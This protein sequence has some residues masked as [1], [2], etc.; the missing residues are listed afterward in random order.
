MTGM[1]RLVLLLV[2][3]LMVGCGSG[4]PETA[5]TPS[6]PPEPP[7]AETGPPPEPIPTEPAPPKG[8]PPAVEETRERIAA[9]ALAEDYEALDALI[10]DTGFTF[11][12]GAGDRATDYW[13][14]LEAS[15]EEPLGTMVGL[16]TLPHTR[17]GDIYVWP[18]AYD[19]DPA[20]LTDEE[21]EALVGAGAAT[22]AQLD[23]MAEFGHYLGWRLGIRRDGTWMF[24][25]AGD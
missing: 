5:G 7:P 13:K 2:L 1:Q 14:D 24:F 19:K 23:Q 16:L 22:R 20:K 6:A 9:A 21:K 11:S 10:P 18:S 8:L 15:G 25:V 17:A 4:D 3:A 12:Y